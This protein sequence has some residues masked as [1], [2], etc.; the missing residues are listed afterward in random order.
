MTELQAA[1]FFEEI[2]MEVFKTCQQSIQV[3][4]GWQYS[5]PVNVMFKIILYTEIYLQTN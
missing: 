1:I 4:N 3:S 2:G 5:C